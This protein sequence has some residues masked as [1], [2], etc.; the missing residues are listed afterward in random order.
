M[1]TADGIM[2][3]ALLLE[4]DLAGSPSRLELTTP[5]G[6]LTV[7]PE[8]DRSSLHGNVVT[9]VG[10]RH[11]AF[12]WSSEHGLSIDGRP[13]ADA[14][15]AHRLSDSVR[16]GETRSVAV[17]AITPHLILREEDVRFERR[18]DEVWQ[19]IRPHGEQTLTIDTRG[20]PTGLTDAVEW[21]I[22]LE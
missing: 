19:I 7:H 14:V 11:L 1:S 15:T 6:L 2:T 16:V 22:E 12:A 10:M 20:I 5:A 9:A 3:H 17:V 8:P 18:G 13:V 4:V 21:P